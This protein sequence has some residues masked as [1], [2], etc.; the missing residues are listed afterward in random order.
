MIPISKF[1]A[2][3]EH[4]ETALAR[5]QEAAKQ[6]E[7]ARAEFDRDLTEALKELA[8]VGAGVYVAHGKLMLCALEVMPRG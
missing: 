2:M 7:T 3:V 4:L 5:S 6:A 8:K 1:C